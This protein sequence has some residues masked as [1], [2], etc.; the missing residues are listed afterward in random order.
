MGQIL[1]AEVVISAFSSLSC[2]GALHLALSLP[3]HQ[4]TQEQ[5]LSL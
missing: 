2:T 5:E 3:R 1:L 4:L